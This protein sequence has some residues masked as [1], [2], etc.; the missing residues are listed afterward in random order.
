MNF[1]KILSTALACAIALSALTACNKDGNSDVPTDSSAWNRDANH[2]WI[3]T[4]KGKQKDKGAHD[5]IDNVCVT[6]E[7][8]V[9]T[10][11]DGTVD[12]YN[13]TEYGDFSR[14]TS[15]DAD[16]NVVADTKHEYD[17]DPNGNM[18]KQKVYEFDVLVE[19]CEYYVDFD[20][21]SII[22]LQT[23]YHED[24][25]KDIYECDGNGN[26]VKEIFCDTEG[27]EWITAE[28]AY[29]YLSEDNFFMSTKNE[30]FDDGTRHIIDYNTYGDI[31]HWYGLDAYGSSEFE[32]HYEYDYDDNG[33]MTYS[34][35]Y[36]GSIL[37]NEYEYA[38]DS[39]GN[40]YCTKETVY[41]EDGTVTYIEYDENMDITSNTT[42][43]ASGNVIG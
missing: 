19:E 21:N 35:E 38:L 10:Y 14:I 7:S 16:G 17:Y 1:K 22:S 9:W 11:E 23:F 29:T 43:D 30:Y 32:F 28:Y 13:Y 34:N 3:E 42:H 37:K 2:H 41:N 8:E 12:I 40:E 26:I 24:G 36:D 18:F 27:M 15:Y 31:I 25:T 6:C 20:G 5:L 4:E 33:N 39:D